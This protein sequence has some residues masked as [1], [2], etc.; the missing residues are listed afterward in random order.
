MDMGSSG[1]W[2]RE[3]AAVSGGAEWVARVHGG[4]LRRKER[5]ALSEWL[6]AS[7][8]NARD[9]LR[10]ETVWRLSG[11]LQSDPRVQEALRGLRNPSHTSETR[12]GRD[13]GRTKGWR[14]GVAVGATAVAGATAAVWLWSTQMPV[15]YETALGEQRMVR[16]QDGSTIALNTDTQ[17]RVKYGERERSILLD[18]GEALFQVNKDPRRPFIV[19]AG[20][21][22]ARAI[23]TRFNVMIDR[24]E[25]VT[26]AVLEGRVEV[27]A[28]TGAVGAAI[29]T[30]SGDADTQNRSSLAPAGGSARVLLDAGQSASYEKGSVQL[31]AADPQRASRERIAAWREGKL[32]FDAWPLARALEEHNRYAVKP[33]RFDDPA[34]NDVRISGVFRIGDTAALL[35]ALSRLIDVQVREDHD[36]LVL[37]K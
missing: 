13:D 27:A 10:A 36:A 31:K 25:A 6:S 17:L 20:K 33:I 14:I 34:L 23:G 24:R 5:R 19:R 11:S 21:G 9:Y 15:G 35:D 12:S 29:T 18:R 30:V 3:P 8:D 26:I 22:Y 16:L 32:R 37:V 28:Q 7:Q 1:R 2:H 4:R